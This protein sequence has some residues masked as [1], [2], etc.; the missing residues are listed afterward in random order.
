MPRPSLKEA[1]TAEI[2]EAYG[3]C[4]ARHGVDGTTLEMTADEAGLARTLIRHNVGNK[5]EILALFVERFLASASQQASMLF[6]SL[7]DTQ[8]VETMIDWLFDPAES[9]PINAGI[10]NALFSAATH[11]MALARRLRNWLDGFT[12]R[13]RAELTEAFGASGE[14]TKAVATGVVS[15]YFSVDTLASLGR[16]TRLRRESEAAARLLVS[17]LRQR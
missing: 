8:R 3:R 11:D 12:D 15:I 9:D 7:P 5:E 1:R 14:D 10:S 17:T 13:I 16:A 4:I 2:L 6:D